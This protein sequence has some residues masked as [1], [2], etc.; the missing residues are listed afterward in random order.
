MKM[1]GLLMKYYWINFLFS[2][3]ILSMLSCGILF[4]LGKYA[5]DITFFQDTDWFVIWILFV[6][7]SIAQVSLATFIQ[8]FINNSKASSIIGYLL[9]IFSVMIG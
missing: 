1:N 6:G 5:F 7:W 4:F 8:I 3:V 2:N 9:S